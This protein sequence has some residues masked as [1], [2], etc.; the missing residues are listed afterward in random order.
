MIQYVTILVFI[1]K[2]KKKLETENNEPRRSFDT[3]Q[4]V[5]VG[6]KDA[7]R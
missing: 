7:G 2:K 4:P 5:R 6:R 3:Q 1:F